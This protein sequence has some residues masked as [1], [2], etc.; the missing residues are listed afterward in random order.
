[1]ERPIHPYTKA[2][3]AASPS[4][5]HVGEGLATGLEE[6][7]QLS[8]H[9]PP[10]CRFAARCP[11]VID[12]ASRRIPNCG[13]FR[14]DPVVRPRATGPKRSA[15]YRQRSCSSCRTR[16]RTRNRRRPTDSA[17]LRLA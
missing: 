3:L 5:I 14:V 4:R 2:L 7:S 17:Q 9:P 16:P 10:G 15:M 13:Q 6:R 11:F 8:C 12:A 1:M